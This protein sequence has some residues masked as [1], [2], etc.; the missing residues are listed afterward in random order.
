MERGFLCRGVSGRF[1]EGMGIIFCLFVL[2]CS[3]GQPTTMKHVCFHG[4]VAGMDGRKGKGMAYVVGCL[5]Y[6]LVTW[7]RGSPPGFRVGL[8]SMLTI[9]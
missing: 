3:L 5:V 7:Q 9:W 2:V 1:L 4:R 6:G 8:D